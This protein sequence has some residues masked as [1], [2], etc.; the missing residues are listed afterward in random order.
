ME[1]EI[2]FIT[3]GARSGKTSFA[4][5]YSESLVNETGINLYYL[6]TSKAEDKEM[7]ARIK[8]HQKD[9]ENS[10]AKWQTI[11]QAVEIGKISNQI[12]RNSIVLVDCITL[13]LS[14]EL[15]KEDFRKELYK[16][17]SYQ[18]QVKNRI[19]KGL[20]E[21]SL[22][23]SYLFIVSNEVLYDS[24]QSDNQVIKIY[25]RLLG[26]IHKELVS[27]ADEAYLLES[28]IVIQKK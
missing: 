21:I 2:I 11:E 8:R 4:E 14:N 3:G 16:K 27:H 9:R 13:L 7:N 17:E 25:Q 5:K 10:H 26:E 18:K 22:K 23:T 1:R 24:L 28:G 19:I 15:Y 12:T 20:L 6:A